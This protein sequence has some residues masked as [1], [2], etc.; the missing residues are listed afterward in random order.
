[1][2]DTETIHATTVSI[3]GRAVMLL[4]PSGSGKSDLA[5]RLIDRGAVLVADDYTHLQRSGDM[6][7]ASAPPTIAGRI[8]V[9]SLGIIPVEH[10]DSM[11]VVLAVRL[12]PATE[13]MPERETEQFASVSVRTLVLDPRPASAPLVIEHALRHDLP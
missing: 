10:V 1:M 8:E 4:G 13:R 5:L 11:P 7:V 6:L 3:G 9:R 12:K 2:S